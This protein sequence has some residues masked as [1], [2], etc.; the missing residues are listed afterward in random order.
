MDFRGRVG[1]VAGGRMHSKWGRSRVLYVWELPYICSQSHRIRLLFARAQ[2]SKSFIHLLP[3]HLFSLF[4]W[5][6]RALGPM[7]CVLPLSPSLSCEIHGLGYSLDIRPSPSS[8]VD[9]D[10]PWGWEAL[11]GGGVFTRT[12]M[13]V[14]NIRLHA[15]QRKTDTG[16]TTMGKELPGNSGCGEE[17]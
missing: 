14:R 9:S 5:V 16:Y 12:H 15:V 10:V 1:L 17:V 4:S 2:A 7:F 3:P 13:G 8:H 11:F 6:T